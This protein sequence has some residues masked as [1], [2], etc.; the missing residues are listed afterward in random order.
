MAGCLR[1]SQSRDIDVPA[2]ARTARPPVAIGSLII[3]IGVR[4]LGTLTGL[5]A[6]TSSPSEAR[7]VAGAAREVA[8]ARDADMIASMHRAVEYDAGQ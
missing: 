2:R 6:D 3:V 7:E 8:V 4:V 1:T 5:L